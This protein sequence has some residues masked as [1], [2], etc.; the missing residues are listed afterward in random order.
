M[1]YGQEPF[2]SASAARAETLAARILAELDATP[3]LPCPPMF[4]AVEHGRIEEVRRLIAAGAD[5]NCY[6]GGGWTPL[7]HA[8]DMESDV[9]W[10]K[11]HEP[12]RASN[13]ITELLLVAGAAP[14]EEAFAMARRYQNLKAVALMES[15]QRHAEP[16]AAVD[17]P[18]AAGC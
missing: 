3:Q 4:Q 7:V 15:H 12:D 11:H 6:Y 10:Q 8:I 18:T 14:T 17:P 16:G 13:E 2:D 1:G 5:V 9:A